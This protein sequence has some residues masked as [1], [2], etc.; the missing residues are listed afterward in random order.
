MKVRPRLA[1]ILAAGRGKRM[2]SSLPKVL[3]E[4]A[5]ANLLEWVVGIARRSG[6]ARIIVVVGHRAD[7]IRRTM[8]DAT[9]EWAVQERQLGTGHALAQVERQVDGESLILVLSGDAPLLR[10]ATA[11]RLLEAA[12]SAWGA[13]VVAAVD[14]PG[15]LGRVRMNQNCDLVRCV[16]AVDAGA[17]DLRLTTVNAGFYALPAPSVFDFLRRVRPDNAQ[18]EIYLP[19]AL[20]E[21]VGKGQRVACIGVE[22]PEEAWGVNDRAELDR[23]AAVLQRRASAG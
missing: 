13:M 5:G 6:C 12:E 20:N 2:R 10:A 16:E 1:V 7:L 17:E 4:A 23:V 9:L 21:A 11:R 14:E 19:A 22:E 3:Q 15:S 18:A 8:A